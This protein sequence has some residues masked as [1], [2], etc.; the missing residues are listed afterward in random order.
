MSIKTQLISQE[1]LTHRTDVCARP[2]ANYVDISIAPQ[3][4]S[5]QNPQRQ[6]RPLRHCHCGCRS[7][8]YSNLFEPP[9]Q[10]GDSAAA[11]HACRKHTTSRYHLRLVFFSSHYI[12]RP[13]RR[14]TR[15]TSAKVSQLQPW[16]L[17]T[18]STPYK[19]ALQ[20]DRSPPLQSTLALE[21][22]RET[23]SH[24]KC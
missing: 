15:A 21:I 10:S 5:D 1:T 17:I 19:P 24:E 8:A 4:Y 3:T 23:R 12:A 20:S 11:A 16:S 14:Y 6:L 22:D 13:L 9:S 18:C 2:M 7:N